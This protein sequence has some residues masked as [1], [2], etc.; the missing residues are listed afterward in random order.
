MLQI[1]LEA[2]IALTGCLNPKVPSDWRSVLIKKNDW[3]WSAT[4]C[5]FCYLISFSLLDKNI[6][7]FIHC[8]VSDNY[9]FS[10]EELSFLLF[11][12]QAFKYRFV[13]ER[14]RATFI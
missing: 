3:W 11:R 5:K 8:L 4:Q 2:L 10:L 12:I 7:A 13:R 1:Q 6:L 9:S 14:I